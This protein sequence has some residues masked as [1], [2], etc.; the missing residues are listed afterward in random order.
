MNKI[1]THVVRVGCIY[2]ETLVS[3]VRY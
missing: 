2:H 3:C 1:L